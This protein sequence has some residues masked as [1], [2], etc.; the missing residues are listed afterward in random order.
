M[1]VDVSQQY[2]A[3]ARWA[4]W[5]AR[6]RGRARIAQV[7]LHKRLLPPPFSLSWERP[8]GGKSGIDRWLASKIIREKPSR[9]LDLGCG[10]GSLLFRIGRQYTAELVGL[11]SSAY[12]IRRCIALARRETGAGGYHFVLGQFT[13]LVKLGRFDGIVAVESLAY[14]EDIAGFATLL[15]QALRPGGNLYILDDWPVRALPEDNPDRIALERYWNR[16]SYDPWEEVT[17]LLSRRDLQLKEETDLT[18]QVP[19]HAAPSPPREPRLL[20]SLHGRLPNNS[21]KCLAAAFL[22]GYHLDRLYQQGHMTYR[23]G[24]FTKTR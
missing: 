13:D 21:L 15:G 22:G 1:T 18:G 19:A 20:R 9:L 6:L 7:C 11:S 17:K 4:W 3:L 24:I 14:L 2:D 8:G 16:R 23:L 10:F 12:P 5:Q